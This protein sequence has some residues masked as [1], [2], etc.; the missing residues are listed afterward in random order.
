[1]RVDGPV[2]FKVRSENRLDVAHEGLAT[3]CHQSAESH[4]AG[5]AI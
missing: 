5:Q 4:P 1:L 3:I 2:R